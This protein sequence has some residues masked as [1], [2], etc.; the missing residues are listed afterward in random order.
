MKKLFSISL[1]ML[2]LAATNI[3]SMSKIEEL[4][5]YL[6]KIKKQIKIYHCYLDNN[7]LAPETYTMLYSLNDYYNLGIFKPLLREKKRPKGQSS[8]I[9][10]NTENEIR[11]MLGKLSEAKEKIKKK[12]V[13]IKK[14][15]KEK[16]EK[17]K[18]KDFMERIDFVI[19]SE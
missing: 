12:I 2:G 7:E 15:L 16:E 8:L 10:F 11:F 18:K 6:R 1:L 19:Q 13:A 3:N 17:I 4:Q 5:K 14:E 9:D